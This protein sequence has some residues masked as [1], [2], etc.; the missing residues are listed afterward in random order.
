MTRKNWLL[1][2]TT[3]A[4]LIGSL[5][6]GCKSSS[7]NAN[8][9]KTAQAK[10]IPRTTTTSSTPKA[11][12]TKP[13]GTGIG[14]KAAS[15]TE[16]LVDLGNWQIAITNWLEVAAI[17]PVTV[18]GVHIREGWKRV[19]I[20]GWL[21]NNTQGPANPGDAGAGPF[22]LNILANGFRYQASIGDPNIDFNREPRLKGYIHSPSL[23]PRFAVPVG[24]AA[25]VAGQQK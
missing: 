14:T 5:G 22:N 11:T 21:I 12:G 17:D 19:V 13:A 4:I 18:N 15:T 2:A 1:G 23:P 20:V 9:T 8:A 7:S 16:N 24:V 3:A 6:V 10:V 25:D